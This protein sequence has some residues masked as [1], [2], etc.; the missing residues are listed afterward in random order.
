[1]SAL[2]DVSVRTV[3]A[4]REE[5]AALRVENTT[6]REELTMKAEAAGLWQGRARTLETQLQQ[7][8]ASAE[9]PEAEQDAPGAPERSPIGES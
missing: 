3:E 5:L 4:L 2:A 8:G 9:R 7:L 6:L 1:M